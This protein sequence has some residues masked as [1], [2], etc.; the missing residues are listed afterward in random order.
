MP[1]FT[2]QLNRTISLDHLPRRI[3]SLVPSQTQL[4]HALGLEEEVIGVTRFC[5]HPDSWFRKKTRVGG[6]KDIRSDIIQSLQPDLIIANKEENQQHQIEAL[7]ANYPVW[8]SDVATLEDALAMINALGTLTGKMQE[9]LSLTDRI[10]RQFQELALLHPRPLRTAYFIWR[11]PWMVAGGDTFIHHM[12]Q[13]CGLSNIFA[14]ENRYP[15][16]TLDELA[17]RRCELV[18]LSSE[19]YPFRDKHIAEIR[20]VLPA[21]RFRLVDGEM[22]SWYGSRLLESPA[23]FRQLLDSL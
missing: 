1:A 19:P 13:Q 18:L 20:E 12:L 5:V 8:V 15:A 6:T 16:I 3:I 4:L 9:A 21:A 14:G 11:D 7:A 22:F 23:C 17:D 10:G 2:D